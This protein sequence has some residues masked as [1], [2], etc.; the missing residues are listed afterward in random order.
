MMGKRTEERQCLSTVDVLSF[1]GTDCDMDHY[2]VTAKVRKRLSV[3]KRAAQ[4]FDME[5]FN[6]KKLND[7]KVEE[8]H[9]VKI[10]NRSS[11]L[12]NLDDVE[13]SMI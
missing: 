7:V 3:T 9:L 10:S 8:E 1:R 12:E 2:L 5:R 4:N 13:N 11:V 6:V